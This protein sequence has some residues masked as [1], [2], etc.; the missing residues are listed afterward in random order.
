MLRI[1]HDIGQLDFRRLMD[2]YEETNSAAGKRDYPGEPENLQVLFAEQ[3]FYG[4][5]EL[6]FEDRTAAYAVWTAEG[7]YKAAL[8]LER[9]LDG[10]LITALEVLPSARRKGVATDLLRAV[11]AYCAENSVSVL[12]SHVH[13]E[14]LASLATHRKCCF[15]VIEQQAAFLDGSI[16]DDHYTLC[17]HK[18]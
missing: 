8:R 16:H 10:F 5:L 7:V 12:Y 6:F 9:Y 18:K 13:K 14:N 3:D 11:Q 2:V 17:W 15:T 4:Y 1:C